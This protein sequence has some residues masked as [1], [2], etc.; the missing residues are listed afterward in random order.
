MSLRLRLPGLRR[1]VDLRSFTTLGVGGKA[2][3]FFEAR[4]T[5]DLI[6]AVEETRRARVRYVTL[7]GGS[8]VVISDR[9]INSLVIVLSESEKNLEIKGRSITVSAG[10]PLSEL[11]KKT[12]RARLRGLETLSG[13]PGSVGG[14]IVG[15]AGAY[16]QSISDHLIQVTAFDG[17]AVRSIEKDACNFSYRE[18]I[19]KHTPWIIT[20]ARFVLKRGDKKLLIER[21]GEIVAIRKKKYPPGL[22]CPGSFFKNVLVRGVSKHAL[23][24]IPR[25]KIIDGKIPAGY[26]LAQVGAQGMRRG[27][28]SIAGYHGNL[29]VNK[30]HGTYHDVRA[31]ASTLKRRVKRKFGITLE[32][33]ICYIR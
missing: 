33:E 5:T 10:T 18:S 2:K 9:R 31:L 8:N 12:I 26:L 1:N 11:I 17:K 6:R 29:L 32:E 3:Y 4:S 15:N 20:E 30:R 16:G 22:R 7:A 21:A 23:T 25:E 19:F 28:I 24:L 27:G 14:A 13:I